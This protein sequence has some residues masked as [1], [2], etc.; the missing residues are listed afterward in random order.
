MHHDSM[1]LSRHPATQETTMSAKE[2]PLIRQR[3]IALLKKTTKNGCTP[4]EAEAALDKARELAEKYAF[5][6]YEFQ[7]PVAASASPKARKPRTKAESD[8]GS[9]KQ[10]GGLGV[11]KLARELI[12]AH[13]DW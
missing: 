11:G 9:P 2:K 1:L 4:A 3:I 7:W 10:A 13:P 12:L 6:P 8:H 5:G